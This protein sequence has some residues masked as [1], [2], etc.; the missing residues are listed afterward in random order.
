VIVKADGTP[1][2]T[3]KDVKLKPDSPSTVTVYQIKGLID[4][5]Y[6]PKACSDL[7]GVAPIGTAPFDDN[8]YMEGLIGAGII[9]PL[10]PA[11]PS[12]A[13]NRY[14]PAAQLLNVTP[15]LPED[16]TV[17][18][19]QSGGL[20]PLQIS[21]TYRA[22]AQ[23][24]FRFD[25][26]FYKTAAGQT[27]VDTFITD[28]DVQALSGSEL[29][30]EQGNAIAYANLRK[31]DLLTRVS[32]SDRSISDFNR[33]VANDYR[34]TMIND[35]CGTERGRTGKLSLF[36]FNLEIAPDTYGPQ[37]TSNT[38]SVTLKNDAVFARLVETLYDDLNR[39]R[40]QLACTTIDGGSSPPLTSS[41]CSELAS[42]WST[43]KTLLNSC[44]SSAFIG[45]SATTTS[46]CNAFR[47]QLVTYGDTLETVDFTLTID[48]A[49]RL[50]EQ[51]SRLATLTRLFDERFVRSILT[52]GWCREKTAP[53][54]YKGCAAPAF[55][56]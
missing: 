10:D 9:I 25:A 38:Q 44:V 36:P 34:D 41:V 54:G 56:P 7:L 15:L 19:N 16:V 48:P 2:V 31:L 33:V 52:K 42:E 37:S 53:N 49:N 5:R 40:S 51:I 29:G 26:L 22:Q 8:E 50:G 13:K 46:R 3:V 12:L 21:R 47:A 28:I 43:G 27:F 23:N 11:K 4:C 24:N 20:P 45:T 30:C 32:E 39:S 14:R 55:S 6:A 17:L 1:V 18:F 35:G